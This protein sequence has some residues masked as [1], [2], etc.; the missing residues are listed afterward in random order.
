MSQEYNRFTVDGVRWQEHRYV[1]TK[2]YGKIP[3]KMQ[4]HHING[5]K[6]DNRIENLKLVT[7]QENRSQ[8]DCWGKGF[9]LDKDGINRV[10]PYRA[11]RKVHGKYID[12]G[13]FG[14]ACGAYM[15]SRMAFVTNLI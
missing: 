9:F 7:I 14:T 2:E 12:F 4:I 1:W 8:Y 5:N 11:K 15:A 10:R 13:R 3:P 6:H